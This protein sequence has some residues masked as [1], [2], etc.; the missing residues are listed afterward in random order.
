[1]E[2]RPG[3]AS[4]IAGI[5]LTTLISLFLLFDGVMKLVQPKAVLDATARIGF[6]T[7]AL[8]PIGIVLIVSTLLYIYPL[9]SVLGAILLTGYLGGA[10]ATQ[11]HAQSTLFETL[12]PAIFGVLIWLSLLLR[13]TRIRQLLPLT[14]A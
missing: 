3:K 10:V 7:N 5:V 13:Q 6:P 11:V 14:R 2:N 1:M 4:R 9:T 8:M 12:F